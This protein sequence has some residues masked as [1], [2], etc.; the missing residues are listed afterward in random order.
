M[1]MSPDK[2]DYGHH[3]YP[4]ERFGKAISFMKA[5]G[6]EKLGII[7][8]ST[9]GMLSLVAASYYEARFTKCG[10][11]TLL[12]ELGIYEL[13]PAMCA[14]D[15]AMSEAGGRS[16]FVRRYTLASGEPYCDCG[17]KKKA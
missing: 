16:V 8:A 14:L 3:N 5:H 17:Y 15:Y 4:L 11:C 13:T 9:T 10:I 2:K 1:A 6:C 12:G 7:G